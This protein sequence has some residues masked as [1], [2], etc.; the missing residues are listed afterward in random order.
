MNT[1]A[2]DKRANFLSRCWAGSARLWQAYWLVGVLGQIIVL[3]LLTVI[4]M[5]LWNWPEHT[6]WFDPFSAVV[7]LAWM[8]FASVSIWRCAANCSNP[9]WGAL[10]KTVVVL[11]VAYGAFTLWRAL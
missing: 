11:S 10:A 5:F 6:S 1:I 8:A 3:A 9:A 4:G 7:L 2:T